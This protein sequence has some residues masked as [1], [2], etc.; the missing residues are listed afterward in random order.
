MRGANVPIL[1]LTVLSRSSRFF[2]EALEGLM[3]N[4]LSSCPGEAGLGDKFLY[5]QAWPARQKLRLF[6]PRE[7]SQSHLQRGLSGVYSG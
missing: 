1:F 5:K 2:M 7:T 3:L 6:G 4:S